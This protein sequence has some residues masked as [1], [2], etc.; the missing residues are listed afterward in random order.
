MKRLHARAHYL[1]LKKTHVNNHF[2]NNNLF[3]ICVFNKK[4][5]LLVNSKLLEQSPR[6]AKFRP[7]N[8]NTR[9]VHLIVLDTKILRHP[10]NYLSILKDNTI[11]KQIICYKL[12]NNILIILNVQKA[13]TANMIRDII[14]YISCI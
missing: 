7:K 2:S 4:L 5:S 1:N 9:I 8:R 3:K 13:S 14:I 12:R 11:K 10:N 6:Y